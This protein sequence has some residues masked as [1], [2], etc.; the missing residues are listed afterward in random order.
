V[1]DAKAR[2]A[3]DESLSQMTKTENTNERS[4]EADE[5][6]LNSYKEEESTEE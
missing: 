3:Q 1:K 4:E 5:M 2:A 6:S